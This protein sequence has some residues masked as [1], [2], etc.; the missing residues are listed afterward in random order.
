[1]SSRP[2][3]VWVL[4][5]G[6]PGHFNQSQGVL[7]QLSLVQTLD[8]HW[9]SV[10]LRASLW[11][12]L[13]AWLCNRLRWKLSPAA[14]QWAYQVSEVPRIMPD[15][16]VGTGGNV[17]FALALW[18]RWLSVPAVFV[19]SLRRIVPEAFQLS[20]TVGDSAHPQR[21]AMDL[22]PVP[23]IPKLSQPGGGQVYWVLLLG[24][25]IEGVKFTR[26]DVDRLVDQMATAAAK[27][28]IHWL[29]STSRRTSSDIEDYLA[30]RLAQDWVADA[31][32]WHKEPR[33]VMRDFLSRASRVYCSIDSHSMITESCVAS[34]PVVAW[35]PEQSQLPANYEQALNRLVAKGYI[36]RSARI[37][38]DLPEAMSKIT[39]PY[40][41]LRQRLA[42]LILA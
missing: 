36:T 7:D 15:L 6:K 1:M 34:V 2:L 14:W 37:D 23:L 39:D 9:V 22:A 42:A 29:V 20:L 35:E 13:L 11:R 32:Y 26:R 33:K 41:T 3:Q 38:T 5:D 17:S 18:S 40:A 10:R 4:S 31:V 24:G 28:G 27:E 25:D 12:Y 16:M 30:S 19:G 8:V 21:L